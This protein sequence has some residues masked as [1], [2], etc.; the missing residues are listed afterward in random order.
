MV[1][2]ALQDIGHALWVIDPGLALAETKRIQLE[3]GTAFE[4]GG[5]DDHAVVGAPLAEHAHFA[6]DGH[7]QHETLVV[8]G[9]LAD[10]VDAAG[11]ACHRQ[12]ALAPGK[13]LAKERHQVGDALGRDN[14]PARSHRVS[15]RAATAAR[16]S[17]A[18]SSGRVS[19]RKLPP[20][21]SA[22]ARYLRRPGRRYGG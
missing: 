18:F 10:E 8:V 9:V 16:S 1:A 20:P 5:V 11:C 21:V 14:G 17:A 13:L 12:L 7:R 3:A 6:V 22:V 2:G 19:F 15:S 4:V